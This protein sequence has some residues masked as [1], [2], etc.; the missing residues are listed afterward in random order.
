MIDWIDAPR[1]GRY[2][3]AEFDPDYGRERRSILRDASRLVGV[4]FTPPAAARRQAVAWDVV[5]RRE[6]ARLPGESAKLSENGRWLATIDDAGVVLV[7]EMVPRRPWGLIL[8]YAAAA[9]VGCW[10]AVAV[11]TRLLRRWWGAGAAG[12]VAGRLVR[13]WGDRRWRRRAAV[14]LGCVGVTAGVVAWYSSA[15]A[16]ARAAMGAVYEQV[17]EGMTEEEVTAL[18]GRPP[19]EGPVSEMTGGRKGWQVGTPPRLRKW[20]RF[21]TELDVWLGE[22]GTVRGVFISEPAGLLDWVERRLGR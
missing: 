7:W 19:V 20:T 14:A 4:S 8:G 6:V 21:G 5:E 13:L 10:A 17:H 15:A 3:A 11:L 9:A 2:L 22:D 18:V 12:R 1:G 16:E